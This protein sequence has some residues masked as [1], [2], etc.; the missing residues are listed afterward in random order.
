MCGRIG[1]DGIGIGNTHLGK[2]GKLLT[3]HPLALHLAPHLVIAPLHKRL[4]QPDRIPDKLVLLNRL[5]ALLAILQPLQESME[6]RVIAHTQ[7]QQQV[8]P[9]HFALVAMLCCRSTGGFALSRWQGVEGLQLLVV[10]REG[11]GVAQADAEEGAE[12]E[13]LAGE[14]QV[15][16]GGGVGGEQGVEVQ[17]GEF[18][19]GEEGGGLGEGGGFRGVELRDELF[20]FFV[21]HGCGSG[22]GCVGGKMV[23]RWCW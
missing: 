19:A 21:G 22:S 6:T 8:Q 23:R 10:A 2:D 7:Q 18:G 11:V 15:V 20:E 1:L 13:G 3:R 17:E 5:F 4:L 12:L 16:G 9:G 14:G